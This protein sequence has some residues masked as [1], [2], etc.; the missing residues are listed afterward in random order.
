MTRGYGYRLNWDYITIAPL[1]RSAG[2]GSEYGAEVQLGLHGALFTAINDFTRST[3]EILIN[4]GRFALCG[5]KGG[6]ARVPA[7]HRN[8]V[9]CPARY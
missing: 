8:R 5:C 2:R 1:Y 6:S 4:H 7:L 9:S 3:L